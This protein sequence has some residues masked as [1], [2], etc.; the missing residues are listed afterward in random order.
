MREASEEGYEEFLVYYQPLTDISLPD[1]PC[2]GAEAL[3][4]W[5]SEQLGFISPG[6]F[7]PIAEKNGQIIPIGDIVFKKVF[8]F[9]ATNNI[10]Q[11]GIDYVE[12]NLSVIQCM[13]RELA[14]NVLSMMKEYYGGMLSVGAT[15]F[16]ET[17]DG[18]AA[19][20]DTGT[21]CHGWSAIPVLFYYKYLL[22]V[23][24]RTIGFRDYNFKP[25]KLKTPL[26]ASGKIPRF[27]RA[28]LDIEI[29]ENGFKLT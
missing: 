28:S 21:L 22:G 11:I 5:N 29:N 25:L 17:E 24:P 15:T 20:C 18:A 26:K 16:W 12:I 4:R 7:I 10:R 19:L 3:I 6:E 27:D 2:C 13:Q 8:E 14:D 1:A 9:I 23:S